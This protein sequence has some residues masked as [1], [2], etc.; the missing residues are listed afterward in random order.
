MKNKKIF[1]GNR[2]NIFMKA[3]GN[4]LA[5][6]PLS[7]V[8]NSIF[9]IPLVVYLNDIGVHPTVNA[10]VLLVPFFWASVLRQYVIDYTYQKYNIQ[11]DPKHLFTKL[12]HKLK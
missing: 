4:S 10:L 1:I 11:I 3:I 12:W 8:L 7:F 9:A 2:K 5:G 6:A